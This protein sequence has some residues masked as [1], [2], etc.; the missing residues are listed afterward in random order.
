MVINMK[1]NDRILARMQ[2][3]KRFATLQSLGNLSR[4]PR[5]WVKAIRESLG[6]T[7]AQLATRIG[8]SQPRVV[9]IEKAEKNG[10]ITMDSLQRAANALDCQLVY[11]LIPRKPLTQLV[12]DRA[13]NIANERLAVTG[14]SMSL[15]AQAVAEDEEK[16]QLEQMVRQII[17]SAGS[18][19]WKDS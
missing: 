15:E 5:G 17:E 2:L 16:V 7:M 4:P 13:R 9:D 10:S 3:D 12:E 18:D 19:I 8:V 11:A 1:S 6:M 14:H